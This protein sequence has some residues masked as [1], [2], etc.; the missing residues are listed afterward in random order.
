MVKSVRAKT[1]FCWDE[2]APQ[3]AESGRILKINYGQ[4]IYNYECQWDEMGDE[5]G[6]VSSLKNDVSDAQRVMRGGIGESAIRARALHRHR[7]W[8]LYLRPGIFIRLF[9][10]LDSILIS[11][12][13]ENIVLH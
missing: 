5:I 9:I 11:K 4:V 7:E 12:P 3:K 6:P 2:I 10:V 1:H 13:S 8:A